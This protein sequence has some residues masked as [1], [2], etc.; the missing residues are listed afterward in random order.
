MDCRVSIQSWVGCP[1]RPD[2]YGV[3]VVDTALFANAAER[4]VKM[5]NTTLGFQM[6]PH[7]AFVT[8][9]LVFEE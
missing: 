5:G 4:T 1:L 3:V 9:E 8:L 7:R 2:V 6:Q